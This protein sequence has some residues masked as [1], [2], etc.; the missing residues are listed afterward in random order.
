MLNEFDLK[1]LNAIRSLAEGVVHDIRGHEVRL[2]M[3]YQETCVYI[4]VLE[5]LVDSPEFQHVSYFGALRLVMISM[6]ALQ[7]SE[8]LFPVTM[9][10][11][12]YWVAVNN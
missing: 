6:G 2:V 10:E 7:E 9:H 11:G 5:Q 12:A 3:P 4:R 1:V 8:K